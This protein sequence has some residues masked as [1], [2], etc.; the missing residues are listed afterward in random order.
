MNKKTN[1]IFI[2][3]G[4]VAV[5]LYVVNVL[6]GGL[7]WPDYSHL[8]QPISD[9]TATGAPDRQLLLLFT[10]LYGILILLFALWLTFVESKKHS[11]QFLWGG[12]C[13]VFLHL[14]SNVYSFFPEDLAGQ[15]VTFRGTM[16]IIL[17]MFIVPVTILSPLLFG[18]ALIK[19]PAWKSFGVYSIITCI[20]IL[21]FGATSG[22]FFAKKIAYFGL[23][24]RLN[25]G[26]LQLWTFIF[27]VKLSY[28]P[29]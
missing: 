5:M 29:K 12:I 19:E 21:V 18:L 1:N 8:Q 22:I 3:L 15:P 4:S 24:E 13:F 28:F 14:I 9:L 16:H 17:T 6:L 23:V 10:T 11:K 20:S 2:L 7:L 27:S 25:I 26:T